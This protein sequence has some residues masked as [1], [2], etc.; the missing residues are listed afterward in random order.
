MEL[1]LLDMKTDPFRKGIR[2]SIAATYDA[3]CPISKKGTLR[4]IRRLCALKQGRSLLRS[5][6][7][8]RPESRC[9]ALY[10]LTRRRVVL[11]HCLHLSSGSLHFLLMMP[12][13][14]HCLFRAP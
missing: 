8:V 1:S 6:G 11:T 14:S 13:A 3:G 12:P 9:N 2:L 4:W 7:A 10:L 5:L